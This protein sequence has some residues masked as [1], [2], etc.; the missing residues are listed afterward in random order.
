MSNCCP[1]AVDLVI[2]H[3]NA[4]SLTH[5]SQKITAKSHQ[6]NPNLKH[7]GAQEEASLERCG[8]FGSGRGAAKVAM[9]A[10]IP[11]TTAALIMIAVSMSSKRC[12]ERHFHAT[13]PTIVA[14]IVLG[15]VTP[16]G[17]GC[18]V[19]VYRTTLLSTVFPFLRQPIFGHV[20]PMLST[21]LQRPVHWPTTI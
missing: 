16:H 6:S 18:C 14:A 8:L 15:Y 11:Y 12:Q 2:S 13:I 4:P 3:S 17:L 7:T 21:R 9:L 1:T 19:S 20:L 5:Q 10:T